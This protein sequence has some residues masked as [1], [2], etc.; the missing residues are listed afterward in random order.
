MASLNFP[1]VISLSRPALLWCLFLSFAGF[2]SA[3]AQQSQNF[4]LNEENGSTVQLTHV[5]SSV[6]PG[7]YTAIRV[8]VNNQGKEAISL[9]VGTSSTTPSNRSE[10]VLTGPA[11]TLACPPGAT[12]VRELIVPLMTEFSSSRSYRGSFLGV[13]LSGAGRTHQARF[14]S[15]ISTTQPFW[16]ISQSLGG[17]AA[18]ALNDAARPKAGKGGS[19][20]SSGESFAG[21]FLPVDLPADWRG[22]MGLD[23]LALTDEEW[24]A[25][26]P[27]V[28][29]AI[30]HW[31]LLGGVLDLYHSGAAPVGVLQELKAGS[32]EPDP[33]GGV[34]G[35]M[36]VG[37]GRVRVFAWDRVVLGAPAMS[38]FFSGAGL[39]IR[40]VAAREAMLPG[41]PGNR[42][43]STL[44]DTLGV[45]SFAAWQVGVILLIFGILVGP[46]NL[47]YLAG[48]GR[49]HRLFVTT[50][51]IAL[52]ASLVLI[53]VIFL[54]DGAGGKGQRAALVELFP[55]ENL[56]TVRQYQISRTGVL[57]G[58]GFVMSELA[59]LT[60]LLLENSRWTRLKSGG[61]SD[62]EGQRFNQP[63]PQAYAG[64]WFQSRSEQAQL[65]ETI[66]PGRG[67]LELKPGAGDP[68][69]VS[70][71]AGALESVFY[72][73]PGGQWWAGAAPL[74]TGG[75]LALQKTD[76]AAFAAWSAE[77]LAPFPP[78]VA[79]PLQSGR[80]AGR[81]YAVSRDPA[82]GLAGTL[83]SIDWANDH[84]FLHGRLAP[85]P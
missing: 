84:A 67:R 31:M 58:G 33:T 45:R 3:P 19:G 47:F 15:M 74:T 8:N 43:G 85:V 48:P 34:L 41:P 13:T 56:S 12:T 24:T 4:P 65:V 40:H 50:P 71:L 51:L 52:G 78:G 79:A 53:A 2:R 73:D 6:P 38:R 16:A 60:P 42:A 44:R 27:G 63:E 80:H 5:F 57:F 11:V 55:D 66:R 49:R 26:A 25:L 37:A 62:S 81:F 70:S 21:S 72:Q 54:Q 10:H 9:V 30:R 69:L 18:A 35:G 75:S 29:T 82:V 14:D 1:S 32:A 7:G 46:V 61:S 76:E 68:V 39:S 20:Y 23:G 64:D 28:R 17:A 59:A 83:Q 77:Q 22:Y 36:P